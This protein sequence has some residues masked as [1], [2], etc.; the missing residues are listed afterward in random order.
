MNIIKTITDRIQGKAAKGEKRSS[1]WGAVRDA[2]KKENPECAVCG[3]KKKVE[4]HHKVPFNLAPDL[5]LNPENFVSL[6]EN[7]KYGINCHLLI[8]HL[9]NYK[10]FNDDIEEDVFIWHRKIKGE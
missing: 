5:E 8:G 10:R 2:Y 7:K 9:G 4:I 1:Q 3:N 6:C